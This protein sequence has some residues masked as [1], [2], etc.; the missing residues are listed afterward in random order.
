[1]QELCNLQDALKQLE[2][3]QVKFEAEL[4]ELKE[5]EEPLE[6]Q[7]KEK[8]QIKSEAVTKNR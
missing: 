6:A 1:M 8:Q 7:L 2:E 3:N 4:V 5:G